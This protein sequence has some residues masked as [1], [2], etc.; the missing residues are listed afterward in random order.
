MENVQEISQQTETFQ[1]QNMS[2]F[3]SSEKK[4]KGDIVF[5]IPSWGSIGP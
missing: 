2:I 3:P 1:L 4:N 5:E